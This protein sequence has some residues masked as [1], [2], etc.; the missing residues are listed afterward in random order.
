MMY[1][2]DGE[3][4]ELMEELY[5]KGNV[6]DWLLEVERVMKESLRITLGNALKAYPEVSFIVISL[7]ITKHTLDCMWMQLFDSYEG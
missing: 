6:E 5:P 7:E 1:S 2:A 3:G 4:V